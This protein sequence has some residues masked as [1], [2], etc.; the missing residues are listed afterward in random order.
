MNSYSADVITIGEAGPAVDALNETLAGRSLPLLG[1]PTRT[2]EGRTVV[3]LVT[4]D[5]PGEA[6]AVC[7]ALKDNGTDARL[8]PVFYSGTQDLDEEFT[9]A[10][11]DIGH[12]FLYSVLPASF[13]EK[14]PEM[15]KWEPPGEGL[16]RPVIAVLD[17]GVGDHRWLPKAHGDP[18][19]LRSDDPDL[20]EKWTSPVDD[21]EEGDKA[22]HATFI[23]GLIR[24]NAPSARVLSVRVMNAQGT[25]DE[26]T[27]VDALGWL[28]R[29]RRD[30]PVDILL[31][32]FGRKP[33]DQDDEYTLV[34]LRTALHRLH[35]AGVAI[36][37]S[38]GNEHQSVGVAPAE[39]DFVNAVGAGFGDYHAVFTNYGDWVDRYREG[40][41][42]LSILPGDQWARWSG[43]SFSAAVFAAD[44]ARPHV[45]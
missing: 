20:D 24:F 29:Y 2:V 22:G 14:P 16:R 43:T 4:P 38:A 41:S 44:L 36:V 28:E 39:F 12:G 33:G 21:T 17:S 18:F 26:S 40:V 34:R 45:V 25:V 11:K 23:A 27:V 13:G 37:A 6:V 10:G 7:Q 1:E 8:E 19:V 31:T 32:A 5:G 35:T 15:P 9:L 3:P 30:H 42:M